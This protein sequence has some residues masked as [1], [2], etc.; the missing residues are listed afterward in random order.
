MLRSIARARMMKKPGR[1]LLARLR[2]ALGAAADSAK[3]PA[4]QAYMKSAMPYHEVPTPVLRRVCRD[5]F[6]TVDLASARAWRHE[7]LRLWRG[8]RYRE[9]RYAAIALS[10]DPRARHFPTRTRSPCTRR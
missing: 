10:G 5:T 4:M 6:A 9:E 7:V 1:P 3:A 2:A 8:A